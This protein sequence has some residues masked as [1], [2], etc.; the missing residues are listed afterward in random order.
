MDFEG[1]LHQLSTQRRHTSGGGR[2]IRL[3][4][5]PSYGNTCSMWNDYN[6]PTSRFE[7]S[8]DGLKVAVVYYRNTTVDPITSYSEYVYRY[9]EDIAAYASTDDAWSGRTVHE[10]TGDS[11]TNT[12]YSTSYVGGA[13]GYTSSLYDHAW[14]FGALTF[15]MAGDGLVFWGGY[16]SYDPD[17]YSHYYYRYE[18]AKSFVGSL[19]SYDFTSGYVRSIL[20]ASN[21]GCNKTIGSIINKPNFS[22]SSWQVDGGLIKPVAGFRSGNG[23]FLYISTRGATGTSS[24]RQRDNALIGVNVRSLNTSAS[25]NGHTDGRGFYV[26]GFGTRNGFLSGHYYYSASNIGMYSYS[27]NYQHYYSKLGVLRPRGRCRLGLGVLHQRD[28]EHLAVL[29]DEQLLRRTHPGDVRARLHL[30]PEGHLRVR[31]EHRRRPGHHRRPRV[32]W[33]QL[34]A[35]AGASNT[36][37]FE[38]R[39][40]SHVSLRF[41]GRVGMKCRQGEM[42]RLGDRQGRLHRLEI[43]HLTDQDHIGVLPQNILERGREVSVSALTSRWLT[44]QFLC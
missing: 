11:S 34:P 29:V 14:R 12:G 4:S 6:G 42:A 27:S 2:G 3:S 16:S 38:R 30:L 35:R 15:T 23:N 24:S 39:Q 9:R 44:M 13:F 26:D 25:I 21:G 10:V 7:I 28:G 8:D 40:Q 22:Y 31:S 37:L 1:E 5:G 32:E 41:E 18:S 20:A 43:A 36:V 17:Q 33:R 19:Y